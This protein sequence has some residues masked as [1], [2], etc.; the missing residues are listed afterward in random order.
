MA[1]AWG[2]SGVTLRG[3]DSQ[4]P[5]NL[6]DMMTVRQAGQ[7]NLRS[8]EVQHNGPHASICRNVQQTNLCAL[9]IGM[10]NGVRETAVQRH[11]TKSQEGIHLA[12]VE[13]THLSG[14]PLLSLELRGDALLHAQLLTWEK[15]MCFGTLLGKAL[16]TH[17][18]SRP[19]QRH[20][21]CVPGGELCVPL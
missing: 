20:I 7:V 19:L 11:Q 16:D 17:F 9:R 6:G 14:S 21:P 5:L 13:L 4:T 3:T 2:S 12:G 8:N 18:R 10:E 15:K 1:G